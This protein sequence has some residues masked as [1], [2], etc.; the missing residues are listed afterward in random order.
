MIIQNSLSSISARVHGVFMSGCP[1]YVAGFII[2]V[3]VDAIN[4]MICRWTATDIGKKVL[5]TTPPLRTDSDTP[6]ARVVIPSVLGIRAAR[7]HGV[8]TVILS[9]P[10][11]M[12]QI[13]MPSRHALATASTRP[14]CT[15]SQVTG[16]HNAGP[17]A[18]APAQPVSVASAGWKFVQGNDLSKPMVRMVPLFHRVDYASNVVVR[19]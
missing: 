17:S 16:A 12:T 14:G 11:M 2:T 4:R 5:E 15:S 8:P 13:S 9:A 1:T 7:D 19:W 18:I 3:V 10:L 6:A